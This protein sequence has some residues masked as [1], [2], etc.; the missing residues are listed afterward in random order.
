MLIS[1]SDWLDSC[2]TEKNDQYRSVLTRDE[3]TSKNT[4]WRILPIP[5]PDKIRN[6]FVSCGVIAMK[7]TADGLGV[8]LCTFKVLIVISTS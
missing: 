3:R 6:R 2:T 1:F 4:H 5:V 8:G 7:E